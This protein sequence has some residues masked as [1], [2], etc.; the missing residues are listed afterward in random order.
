[1]AP[2]PSTFLFLRAIGIKPGFRRTGSSSLINIAVAAGVGAASGYYIFKQP[3]EDFYA[4]H[5]ELLQ[6]QQ[7]ANEK[8]LNSRN[9]KGVATTKRSDTTCKS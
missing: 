3:I 7:P 8:H 9:H 2:G 1:M 6:E 4:E 5:P